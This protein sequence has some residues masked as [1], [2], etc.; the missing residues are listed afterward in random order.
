MKNKDKAN[1]PRDMDLIL[2]RVELL[3]KKVK[4]IGSSLSLSKEYENA[5]FRSDKNFI[6]SYENTIIKTFKINKELFYK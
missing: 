1:D 5:I 6:N 3:E 2:K 4:E